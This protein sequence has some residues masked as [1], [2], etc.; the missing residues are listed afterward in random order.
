MATQQSLG[1]IKM[2]IQDARCCSPFE[3]FLPLEDGRTPRQAGPEAAKQNFV[4]LVN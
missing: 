3:L 1:R 2:G 4:A